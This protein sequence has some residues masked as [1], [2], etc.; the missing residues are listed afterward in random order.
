MY[1]SIRG[2]NP[3]QTCTSNIML[4]PETQNTRISASRSNGL[5]LPAAAF[6]H[7]KYQAL[8]MYIPWAKP[9][10]GPEHSGGSAHTHKQRAAQAP[11]GS[12]SV[13]ELAAPG[14]DVGWTGCSFILV[15]HSRNFSCIALVQW[16][17]YA[18]PKTAPQPP[19][20]SVIHQMAF[21][22]GHPS[23]CP[24]ENPWLYQQYSLVAALVE[25]E[26]CSGGHS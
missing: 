4:G 24:L 17:L 22:R 6:L 20:K 11:C 13:W 21:E 8:E 26:S 15:L 12:E 10:T 7:I 9:H 18:E 16:N 19:Q 1:F 23:V 14:T 5:A 3:R 2:N 25:V